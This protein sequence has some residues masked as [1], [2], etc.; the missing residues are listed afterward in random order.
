MLTFA[1]FSQNSTYKVVCDKTDNKLKVVKAEN[2]SSNF[3]PVKS[4]FPFAA[5]ARDWIKDNYSTDDCDAEQLMNDIKN[6]KQTQSQTQNQTAPVNQQQ[7]GAVASPSA[8]VYTPSKPKP[9]FKNTSFG[10]VL[11]FHNLDQILNLDENKLG[12]GLNLEHVFGKKNFCFGTGVH[13]NVLVS[14]NDGET[15]EVYMFKFPVFAGYRIYFKPFYM[16]FEGGIFIHTK[17]S[18]FED[19]DPDLQGKEPLNSSFSAFPRLRIG[20][21]SMQ[22]ELGAEFWLSEV[23]E[24]TDKLSVYHLGLRFLF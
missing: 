18:P 13:F 10:M 6:Q 20:G 23:F 14:K 22:I 16:S 8:P 19:D 3:V 1:A 11:L 5:I 2:H 7:T 9:V 4:G 21:K 15:V 24:N 17:L 12:M